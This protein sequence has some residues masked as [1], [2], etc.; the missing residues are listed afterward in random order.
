MPTSPIDVILNVESEADVQLDSETEVVLKIS[1]ENAGPPGA[2]GPKGDIGSKGDKGDKGDTGDQGPAGADGAP[3]IDGSPGAPGADGAPGVDGADGAD[4]SSWNPAR[5][6][7]SNSTASLAVD[8]SEDGVWALGKALHILQVGTDRA[9]RV[10][11][12]TNEAK[13][14]AD[15]ARAIGTDPTTN[16]GCLLDIVTTGVMILDLSPVVLA[17]SEDGEVAYR[18]TNMSGGASTVAVDIVKYVLEA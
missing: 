4:G 2:P 3:G 1:V 13:R 10:R 9:S 5:T 7:D 15:A 8:A 11:L 6:T 12:Y 14:N 18:V 17:Y 16:A